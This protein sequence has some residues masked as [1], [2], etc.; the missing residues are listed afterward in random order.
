[1]C[2]QMNHTAV[3]CRTYAT[4]SKR[5]HDPFPPCPY[6]DKV[7]EWMDA[8]FPIYFIVRPK[9]GALA[10][11]LLAPPI[12]VGGSYCKR[13]HTPAHNR[14]VEE[15]GAVVESLSHLQVG[16]ARLIHEQ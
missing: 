7:S 16:G 13:A 9:I 3:T 6:A 4:G 5:T 1:M 14:P 2:Y 8:P 12:G 15:D 10:V 11:N